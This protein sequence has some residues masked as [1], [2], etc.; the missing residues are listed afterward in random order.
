MQYLMKHKILYLCV[1][2]AAM[3]S[4]CGDDLEDSTFS[5]TE[6]VPAATW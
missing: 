2:V 3:F 5:I 4:A 6:E 1:A